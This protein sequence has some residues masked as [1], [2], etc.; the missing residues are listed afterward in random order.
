[1]MRKFALVL[2]L[3]FT[4]VPEVDAAT[5]Y[6]RADGTGDAPTIA[7]GADSAVAGDTVLVG[8][9]THVVRWG[10]DAKQGVVIVSEYGPTETILVPHVYYPP[11]V[12]F[13]AFDDSQISGFWMKS[14]T[15]YGAIGVPGDNVL[16]SNNIIEVGGTT[17][18]GIQIQGSCTISN[19]LI[20]GGGVGIRSNN[21]Y[22]VVTH[23]NII[24]NGVVC[25]DGGDIGLSWCDDILGERS[26][27]AAYFS[28]DPEFCGIP[29]ADNYYL[30]ADSPCAPGNHPT[31]ENCGLIG[32]LPVGC[33]P[34][35]VEHKTW[36][37]IKS[38]YKD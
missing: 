24:L 6:I 2:I 28:L 11:S 4:I 9:G 3:G 18:V 15:T 20:L 16:I 17:I 1:M 30:Q 27:T 29:G 34:V 12:Y 10:A 36:G 8:P 19:N 7:A 13:G 23:N 14:G 31:G 5:W 21:S 33:G 38:M 32:P 26:C 25:A 35:P 22:A 37:A